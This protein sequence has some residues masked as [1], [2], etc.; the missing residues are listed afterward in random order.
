MY[1]A[2][3]HSIYGSSRV[4]VDNRK[5]TLYIAGSYS[6][7]WGGVGT[8][9]RALGLKSFEIAN[10]LGNVLV[11]VSDKPVYKVSSGTIYFQPE[12][13]STSDYYPFGAPMAGR[14]YSSETYRFG[15]NGKE[16]DLEAQTQDYG[17]RIYDPRLGRFLSVDP[18]G[19][20][21]P[22]WS[23]YAAFADN[24]LYYIDP[25]GKKFVNFDVQG[26]YVGTTKDNWF[27][28]LF[29]GS[30]GRIL[31]AQGDVTCKFSFADPKNDVAQ[32]ESGIINKLVVVKEEEEIQL[33]MVSSRAINKKNRTENKPIIERYDYIM[34]EGTG[35]GK[36]DF[37]YSQIPSV[38]PGASP[39]PN[40]TPSSLIFLTGDVAHNQ[41]NFGNFLF[42][43]AGYSLGLSIP[44]LLTGA[45]YNSLNLNRSGKNGYNPQFDSLDDQYS[46]L[47]GVG[48]ARENNYRDKS[49]D[50]EVGPLTPTTVE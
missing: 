7:S 42:G 40:N 34:K 32:I 45:H 8:S 12:I 9:R 1:V 36:L 15:F 11:T 49:V 5:D 17:F 10:H 19:G 3:E 27:H 6:P 18:L 21:A 33:M 4:G 43:A 41:M 2:Q 44:E 25:N 38:F 37:S 20:D 16:L 31:D 28:N 26:N 35:G 23:S 30:K 48:H 24:P 46:I 39:D 29:M 22:N 13:T 50:I 14:G 47:L